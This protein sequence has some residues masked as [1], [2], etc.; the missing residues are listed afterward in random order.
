M[1]LLNR[2]NEPSSLVLQCANLQDK[3]DVVMYLRDNVLANS[4]TAGDWLDV[5]MLP[6]FLGADTTERIQKWIAYKKA[7]TALM[8]SSQEGR[9]FNNNTFVAGYDDSVK[10]QVI[11]AFDLVL[12]RIE[13]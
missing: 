2:D 4:G 9:G 7:G 3:Y 1:Y 5:S 10:A 12:L 6:T 11:Q 8:D 13:E